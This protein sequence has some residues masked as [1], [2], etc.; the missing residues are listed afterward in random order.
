LCGYQFDGDKKD[1]MWNCPKCRKF[2]TKQMLEKQM[3]K[4][5]YLP[6]EEVIDETR[7]SSWKKRTP[8]EKWQD[9][10]AKAATGMVKGVTRAH[11]FLWGRPKRRIKGKKKAP[12]P[13]NEDNRTR[14]QRG[15]RRRDK[16]KRKFK[17]PDKPIIMSSNAPTRPLPLNALTLIRKTPSGRKFGSLMPQ[18]A[19]GRYHNTPEPPPRE[20]LENWEMIPPPVKHTSH[21]ANNNS[22]WE[23]I[24]VNNNVNNNGGAFI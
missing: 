6:I 13:T 12:A 17:R 15:T 22:N 23:E 18:E 20:G 4:D 16:I 19:L 2:I 10:K 3:E 14:K 7:P 11:D 24:A 9:V 1:I 5:G 21:P 8:R